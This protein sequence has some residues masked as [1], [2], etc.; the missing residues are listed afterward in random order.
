MSILRAGTLTVLFATQGQT[1]A[2]LSED[3]H[4]CLLDKEQMVQKL[5][6]AN[7]QKSGAIALGKNETGVVWIFVS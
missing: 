5:K 1:S 3:F 2:W 6:K 4:K 7:S